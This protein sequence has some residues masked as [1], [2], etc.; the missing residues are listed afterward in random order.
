MATTIELGDIISALALIFS[1]YATFKTVQFNNRQKALIET[2]ERLNRLLLDKEA[3]EAKSG[4]QADLGA[5]FVRLGSSKYR[6]KV[7]N[8]GKVAA[9]NVVLEFPE[10]NDAILDSDLD[11]K[12]PLETLEPQQGVELIA[13]V[14]LGTKAKHPIR[15]IWAD[16]Y[17]ERNEKVVIVTL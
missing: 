2:Q 16:D 5:S 1:I 10:G 15:F 14:G 6:L 13:V 17:R 11:E 4:R 3:G 7:F 8:R 9:R 12:F